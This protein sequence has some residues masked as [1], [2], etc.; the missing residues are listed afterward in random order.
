M[1]ALLAAFLGILAV[2]A[3]GIGTI[4]VLSKAL[5][6]MRNTL[7]RFL[8]FFAVGVPMLFAY[9]HIKHWALGDHHYGALVWPVVIEALVWAAFM[10]LLPPQPASLVQRKRINE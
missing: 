1:E 6:G 3:L 4:L 2:G 10:A 8:L 9:D 7:S 5:P